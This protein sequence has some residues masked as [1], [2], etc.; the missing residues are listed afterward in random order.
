MAYTGKGQDAQFLGIESGLIKWLQVIQ[1]AGG[2]LGVTVAALPRFQA[3]FPTINAAISAGNS[4]I[5]VIGDCEEQFN[6]SVP[7]SGLTLKIFADAQ[8]DMT[9]NSFLWSSSAGLYLNGNG[10]M[11]HAASGIEVTLFDFS[12]NTGKLTVDGIEI[13]NDT[14]TG[15]GVLTNGT[16]GHFSKCVFLGAGTVHLGGQRNTIS[17]SDITGSIVIQSGSTNNHVSD[18]QLNV[19]FTDLGSGTILADINIY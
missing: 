19:G 10:S 3:N 12:G 15:S 18:C 6:V 16:R 17:S 11:R 7:S 8:V 14:A 1:A 5:N 9:N 4:I 13:V 2:G